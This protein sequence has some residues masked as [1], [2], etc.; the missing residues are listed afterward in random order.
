M[1]INARARKA[2]ASD[3]IDDFIVIR[4]KGVNSEE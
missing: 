1:D 2:K 4:K 3:P